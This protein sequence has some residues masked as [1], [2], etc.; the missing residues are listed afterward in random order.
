MTITRTLRPSRSLLLGVAVD[1]RFDQVAIRES[2][3]PARPG[4][5]HAGSDQ[6]KGLFPSSPPGI[7]TRPDDR[8]ELRIGR[9][10]VR[11]IIQRRAGGECLFIVDEV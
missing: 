2:N 10:R 6:G 4:G 1:R 3:K 8:L 5:R 9:P 7:I 11:Y